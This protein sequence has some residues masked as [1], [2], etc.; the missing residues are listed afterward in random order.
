VLRDIDRTFDDL[1]IAPGK[2]SWEG[3][4][5]LRA[6]ERGPLRHRFRHA[7][8]GVAVVRQH[9]RY[10]FGHTGL[11]LDTVATHVPKRATS[12]LLRSPTMEAGV[13]MSS[14]VAT[15]VRPFFN[16]EAKRN[17]ASAIITSYARGHQAADVGLNIATCWL[18]G[19]GLIAMAGAMAIQAPLVYQPMARKIAQTYL[20]TDIDADISE[21]V[22]DAAIEG[23]EYDIAGAFG[24]EFFEQIFIDIL[25]E[26]G[27]SAAISM[28]PVIGS[29]V[30]GIYDAKIAATMTWRVGLTTALY[31]ENGC[32]WLG[33]DRH[34]TYD[35][36]KLLV[37]GG[38][39][40][41]TDNRFDFQSVGS[42]VDGLRSKQTSLLVRYLQLARKTFGAE[43]LEEVLRSHINVD[44]ALVEA[45]LTEVRNRRV[46]D[47]R[48]SAYAKT[49]YV[50]CER[51][52]EQF[53]K[54]EAMCPH[55]SSPNA[56]T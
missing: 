56:V 55:C 6:A 1:G 43:N 40:A 48:P 34:T 3:D 27:L 18:P 41:K 14:Q 12:L 28:V 33:G 32:E 13:Q 46:E 2:N 29:V 49:R 24:V 51:C 54:D 30:A 31:Y 22:Q 5:M 50:R 37:T 10:G 36:A 9:R 21:A 38:L 25:Q 19:G 15:Q 47:G 52:R 11:I 4:A 26:V 42:R 16:A 23:A 35:K 44:Q 8:S 17:S 20:V 53:V 45:I 7:P 39:S